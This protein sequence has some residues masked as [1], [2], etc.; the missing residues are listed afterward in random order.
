MQVPTQEADMPTYTSLDGFPDRVSSALK[1]KL[2]DGETLLLGIPYRGEG[3]LAKYGKYYVLTDS[4]FLVFQKAPFGVETVDATPTGE[5]SRIESYS[6]GSS[7][8]ITKFT[9][10]GSGFEEEYDIHEEPDEEAGQQFVDALRD[11]ISPPAE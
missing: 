11:Q 9:L 10:Y 5:I 7:G 8:Y 2:R 1:S 6:T 4:R 3:F